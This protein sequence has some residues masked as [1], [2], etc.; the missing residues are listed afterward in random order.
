MSQPKH[1]QSAPKM[2]APG[3]RRPRKCGFCGKNLGKH[4]GKYIYPLPE[5]FNAHPMEGR[6]ACNDCYPGIFKEQCTTGLVKPVS[7]SDRVCRDE[8]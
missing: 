2:P 6:L 3:K 8:A 1:R 5:R 4:R 7:E